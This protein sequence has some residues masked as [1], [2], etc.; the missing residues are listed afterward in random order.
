M[1]RL[2]ISRV[3][4][5]KAWT[6][7]VQTPASNTRYRSLVCGWCAWLTCALTINL[8][9]R[10]CDLTE[11][12]RSVGRLA[13]RALDSQRWTLI[14]LTWSDPKWNRTASSDRVRFL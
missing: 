11:I 10:R 8:Y 4:I 14:A 2:E 1:I 3:A 13:Q 5:S 6:P 7:T 12:T 9:E